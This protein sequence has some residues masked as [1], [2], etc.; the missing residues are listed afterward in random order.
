MTF[1]A[2]I[3]EEL[4]SLDITNPECALAECCGMI[5]F[6]NSTKNNKIKITTENKN[7]AHRA[8]TLLKTLFGFDFDKK[9]VP[10]SAL[11]KFNLIIEHKQRIDEVFDAFGTDPQ[12]STSLHL[13]AAIVETDEAR[14]AFCRGAFLTGGSISDPS[15]RYHLELVTSHAALSREVV[16]LLLE[17]Q[18]PAKLTIRKSNNIIYFKESGHIEDFLTRIGSP[19]SA[20]ELMQ[21]KLYKDVRNNINR[22]VNFELA[23]LSKTIDA[24]TLQLSAIKTL[25]ECGIL[26]E[27]PTSLKTAAYLRLSNPEAS[28][29]ELVALSNDGIGKSGL[30]HRLNKL[31]TISENIISGKDTKDK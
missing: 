30:N 4:T 8:S 28:L 24:A 11:K 16:S 17:L 3:K 7:V 1:S 9:I 20:L 5:L 23:N 18:L 29:S 10:A 19:L 26:E 12:L 13:N 14:S 27:L 31:V 21:T 25:S 2:R 6:A 22:Q 15:S